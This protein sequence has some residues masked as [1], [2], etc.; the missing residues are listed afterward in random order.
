MV[1]ECEQSTVNTVMVTNNAV[2]PLILVDGDEITGAKQNRI[3]NSTI[4]IPPKTT[5]P[6]SVSCTEHGRW[7]FKG[8]GS[9][10]HFSSSRYFANSDTRRAKSANLY[11]HKDF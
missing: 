5:M 8:R 10:N 4:L 6:V 7:H 3:V 9:N 2:T 1:K 11:E